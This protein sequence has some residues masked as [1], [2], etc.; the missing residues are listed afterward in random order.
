[1]HV[2]SQQINTMSMR[3]WQAFLKNRTGHTGHAPPKGAIP[4]TPPPK[5]EYKLNFDAAY[6][7]GTTYTGVVLR[8]EVGVVL[9][10]WTKCFQSENSFCA[11]TVAAVQA[12]K[13]AHTLQLERVTI[14]GD[15]LNVIMALSGVSDA[16]DWKAKKDLIEG[17]KLVENHM[18]WFL[19]FTPRSGNF[20]AHNLAS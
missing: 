6:A 16:E 20:H 9:G 12:L 2:L 8:N 11:K 19:N 3:Y 18:I 4:W 13:I 17:K 14:E 1:M 10:A 15:A 7:H 5:G